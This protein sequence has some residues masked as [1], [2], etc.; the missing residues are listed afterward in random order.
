MIIVKRIIIILIIVAV[1]GYF[2]NDYYQGKTKEKREQIAQETALQ[3]KREARHTAIEQM[4]S[5]YNAVNDWEDKLREGSKRKDKER[6]FKEEIF[7]MELENLWLIN[8]P[9][10]FR[11]T[12]KD[13]S[14]LDT[15][16]YLMTLDGP[17]KTGT[18][19]ALALKSPKTVIDSFLSTHSKE[20]LDDSTPVAVI[21]KISKIDTNYRV[22]EEGY[23]KEKT[24]TE[25]KIITGIGQ[26][27]D[28]LLYS[29][30][31]LY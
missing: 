26:C 29:E 13:I 12:I 1:G 22:T 10:L 17:W 21:A 25:G 20:A 11:G 16:N 30:P 5:K 23:G 31:L 24:I 8:R 6:F 28:I 7:T 4:V 9:I 14:A 19:W 2:I 15:D 3:E 18:R 27:I